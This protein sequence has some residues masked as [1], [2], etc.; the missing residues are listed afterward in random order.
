ME[1]YSLSCPCT[2]G[3]YFC[4]PPRFAL[5][6]Y[7]TIASCLTLD[8][9]AATASGV[10]FTSVFA[11]TDSALLPDT[12]LRTPLGRIL[13]SIARGVLSNRS[14]NPQGLLTLSITFRTFHCLLSSCLSRAGGGRCGGDCQ[15]LATAAVGDRPCLRTD[16]NEVRGTWLRRLTRIC[17]LRARGMPGRRRAADATKSPR[18]TSGWLKEGHFT[19]LEPLLSGLSAA[20]SQSYGNHR[21]RAG[22]V[23]LCH[24]GAEGSGLTMAGLTSLEGEEAGKE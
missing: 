24:T 2:K 23:F 21:N 1:A 17:A 22:Q 18:A 14:R 3:R 19:R 11:L 7:S 5:S 16:N 12:H 8:S 20:L 13:D 15:I 6:E 9:Q 10:G 4:Q